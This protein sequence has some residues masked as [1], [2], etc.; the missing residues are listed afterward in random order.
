[1]PSTSA[2]PFFASQA[3][4]PIMRAQGGGHVIHMASQLGIVG[5]HYAPSTA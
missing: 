4:V 1:L 5:T 3:V 2:R